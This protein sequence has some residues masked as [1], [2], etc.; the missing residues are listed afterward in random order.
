MVDEDNTGPISQAKISYFQIERSLGSLKNSII[1]WYQNRHFAI[2]FSI[3][4]VG[5][6]AGNALYNLVTPVAT[7]YLNELLSFLLGYR[8]EISG[9]TIIQ[10][11]IALLGV[12]VYLNLILLQR[13]NAV[14]NEQEDMDNTA[15]RRADGGKR[16]PRDERG[17]F[18]E[19]GTSGGGAIGGMIIGAAIGASFGPGGIVGGAIAGALLGDALEQQS[20]DG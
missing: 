10:L 16:L 2:Q 17:R 1:R 8:I 7:N 6:I 12:N 18:K 13:I 3:A 14:Q 4:I 15:E 11:I 9:L 19:E 5:W 20:Q